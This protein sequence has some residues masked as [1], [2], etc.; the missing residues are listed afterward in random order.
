M[1]NNCVK[2]LFVKKNLATQVGRKF[3][4]AQ[5]REFINAHGSQIAPGS[6][7]HGLWG[8]TGRLRPQFWD[9]WHINKALLSRNTG[10]EVLNFTGRIFK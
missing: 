2:V 1:K 10:T 6:G 7:E 4:S 8:L 5:N 9:A 3:I